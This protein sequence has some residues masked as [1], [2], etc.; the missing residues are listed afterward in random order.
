M[1]IQ[2]LCMYVCMYTVYVHLYGSLSSQQNAELHER[3]GST[4]LTLQIRSQRHPWLCFRF[5]CRLGTHRKHL[6]SPLINRRCTCVYTLLQPLRNPHGWGG[7]KCVAT[8]H[9]I[10]QWRTQLWV[11]ICT[12]K[13]CGNEALLGRRGQKNVRYVSTYIVNPAYIIIGLRM[14]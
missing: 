5:H 10:S 8:C 11:V 12:D 6:T 1:Y 2:Y 14:C 4:W 9:L 3:S 7:N 13:M